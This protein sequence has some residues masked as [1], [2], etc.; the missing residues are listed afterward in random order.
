VTIEAEAEVDGT[1]GLPADGNGEE[2]VKISVP[3]RQ[4]TDHLK[5][6]AQFGWKIFKLPIM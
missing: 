1:I 4:K 2:E 5:R 3:S 6:I